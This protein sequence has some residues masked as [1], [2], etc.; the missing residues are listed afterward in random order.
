MEI[1]GPDM[2]RARVRAAIDVLGGV[3]K[4]GMKKLDKEYRSVSQEIEKALAE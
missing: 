4:K 2:S 1:I 3:S